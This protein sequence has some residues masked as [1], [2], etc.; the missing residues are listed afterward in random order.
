MGIGHV[1]ICFWRQ[2]T[3]AVLLARLDTN[4]MCNRRIGPAKS[5][6]ITEY[7]AAKSNLIT[8]FCRTKKSYMFE[9][10]KGLK[11]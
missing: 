10:L 3:E 11:C 9:W 7:L 1:S 8:D 5:I 6:R 2:D 4:V